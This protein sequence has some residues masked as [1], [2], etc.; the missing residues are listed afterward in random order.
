MWS[1]SGRG[2]EL[3]EQM[4]HVEQVVLHGDLFPGEVEHRDEADPG[5]RPVNP[6]G[7]RA[8]AP[9]GAPCYAALKKLLNG[10]IVR[11]D[12]SFVLFNPGSGL[13][14]LECFAD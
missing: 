10:G 9:E 14:Y 2:P 7:H 1:C 12:E 3:R 11:P 4:P 8:L 6:A 5:G 13:K